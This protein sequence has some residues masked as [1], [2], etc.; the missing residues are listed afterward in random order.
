M[1]ETRGFRVLQKLNQLPGTRSHVDPKIANNHSWSP[2]PGSGAAGGSEE[3]VVGKGRGRHEG[4]RPGRRGQHGPGAAVGG[5]G[6]HTAQVQPWE[7]SARGPGAAIGGPVHGPGV[8]SV[9]HGLQPWSSGSGQAASSC[10]P[11]PS[12]TTTEHV[13]GLRP[14]RLSRV[15][16]GA[17]VPGAARCIRVPGSP[18]AAPRVQV[19]R[20]RAA[21]PPPYPPLT[22]PDP[23]TSSPSSCSATTWASAPAAA[24]SLLPSPGPLEQQLCL[25]RPL[26]RTQHPAPCPSTQ[27]P[28]PSPAPSPST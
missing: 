26:A 20:G 24:L 12:S 6:Q 25:S 27:N 15:T 13:W 22:R 23:S 5:G 19:P 9:A 17:P 16:R 4:A 11:G 10:G 18:S 2:T 7:G 1:C 28:A 14:G 3:R 21:L 8:A